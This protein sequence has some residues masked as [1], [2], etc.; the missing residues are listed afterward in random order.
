MMRGISRYE[1]AL[2]IFLRNKFLHQ[3]GIFQEFEVTV[4]F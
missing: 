2:K 1:F 4:N 3:A